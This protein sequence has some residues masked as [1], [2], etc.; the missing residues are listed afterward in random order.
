MEASPGRGGFS[1]LAID[2]RAHFLRLRFQA[3]S[4]I[5]FFRACSVQR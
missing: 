5:S 4:I 2:G 1:P 3:H